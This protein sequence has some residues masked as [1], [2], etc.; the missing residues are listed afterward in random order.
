MPNCKNDSKKTYIGNEPSPKGL[1][2][3]AHAELENK[4]MKGKDGNNWIKS[5]GR[6]KKIKEYKL[7]KIIK[8]LSKKMYTWFRKIS[9]EGFYIINKENKCKFYKYKETKI[10]LDSDDTTMMLWT[11]Q[12]TDNLTFF[13]NY[14]L[15]KIDNEV[16]ENLIKS[17][18]TLLYIL[19]NKKKFLIK[20]KLYTN[21]DYSL[22]RK[23]KIND[24]TV[25]KKLEKSQKLLTFLK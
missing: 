25:I 21:K 12:S 15:E 16:I 18:N 3:C 6:W 13:I 10:L 11:S 8:I 14:I 19:D 5:N 20:S 17:K 9:S 22:Q 7:D 2:Y 4:I 23:E 1:G 24:T